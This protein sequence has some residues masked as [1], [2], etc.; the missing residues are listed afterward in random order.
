MQR[1]R[2]F[3]TRTL[4]AAIAVACIVL[5]LSNYWFQGELTQYEREVRLNDNDSAEFWRTANFDYERDCVLPK[6]LLQ[7]MDTETQEKF[8]RIT[9]LDFRLD[10]LN[11]YKPSDIAYYLPLESVHT[12]KIKNLFVDPHMI[13]SFRQFPKLERIE[14]EFFHATKLNSNHVEL[15]NE[16]IPGVDIVKI[17]G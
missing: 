9:E 17:G 3:T 4:L 5:A 7:W 6:W 15:T 1:F 11:Y 8:Y 2:R 12:I 13:D 10:D 14:V 16:M